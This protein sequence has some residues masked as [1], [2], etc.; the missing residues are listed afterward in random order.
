MIPSKWARVRVTMQM[1]TG[2]MMYINVAISLFSAKQP[3]I[4]TLVFGTK[5]I[6]MKPGIDNHVHFW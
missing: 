5:V 6:A 2:F 1:I 3:T 4:E